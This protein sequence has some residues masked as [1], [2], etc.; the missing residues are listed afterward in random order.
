MLSER[1][2]WDDQAQ[3]GKRWKHRSIHNRQKWCHSLHIA[4]GLECCGK[5]DRWELLKN[6]NQGV[7]LFHKYKLCQRPEFPETSPYFWPHGFTELVG[8]LIH[9]VCVIT[10]IRSR[11]STL[12]SGGSGWRLC[13][14][15]R[16]SRQEGIL[17]SFYWWFAIGLLKLTRVFLLAEFSDTSVRK[18]LSR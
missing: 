18:D 3:N 11:A 17:V 1:T 4:N 8:D 12:S 14:Y 13:A 7:V 10:R 2:I 6:W 16:R 9:E 15:V 5:H